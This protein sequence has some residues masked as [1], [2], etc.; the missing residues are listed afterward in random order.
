MFPPSCGGCGRALPFGSTLEICGRCRA[1][2]PWLS[3]PFCV[4]CGKRFDVASPQDADRFI[5]RTCSGCRGRRLPFS[6]ARA[7]FSYEGP[8][9]RAIQAMKFKGRKSLA[10]TFAELLDVLRR[11]EPSVFMG[12]DMVVPVPLHK[13]RQGERG[14]NQS[15]LLARALAERTGMRFEGHAIERNRDTAT[16]VGLDRKA[17]AAN[18][19]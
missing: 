15:A 4:K 2:L 7:A 14:Y 11:E 9:K 18:G 19:Q 13:A 10:A 5:G 8:A 16:Q 3:R 1:D 12:V 17:R 6:F